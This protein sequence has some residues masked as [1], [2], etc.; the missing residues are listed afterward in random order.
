MKDLSVNNIL[1]SGQSPVVQ[2]DIGGEPNQIPLNKDLGS[3]AY[4][5]AP[6]IEDINVDTLELR[7]MAAEISDTAVDVFVYDTR[8]DSD[9]GAWRSRTQHTSWYNEEL[10]TATRGGR[11]EFPAVAVIVAESDKIIIYDGDDPDLPM[12]MIFEGGNGDTHFLGGATFTAISILNGKLICVSNGGARECD[13]ISEFIFQRRSSLA[14]TKI[15]YNYIS[16]RNGSLNRVEADASSSELIVNDVIH[17]VA[18]TVLPNAP[19]DSDTG[20]PVPTIAVATDGGVS[21]IRDNGSVVDSVVTAAIEAIIFDEQKNLLYYRENTTTM[22]FS[23]NYSSASFSYDFFRTYGTVPANFTDTSTQNK[24]ISFGKDNQII[25]GSD[26]EGISRL[27]SGDGVSQVGD[28]QLAAYTTSTYNTGWMPGDIKLATLSDTKNETVGVDESELVSNGTFD[29]NTNNWS[30]TNSTTLSVDNQRLKLQGGGASYPA[31]YTSVNVVEGVEYEVSAEYISNSNSFSGRIR[32][33]SS[34]PLGAD[35]VNG[36]IKTA[37]TTHI[38]RFTAPSTGSVYIALMLQDVNGNSSGIWDNV[39]VKRVA[40]LVE[41]GTFDSDSD[42]TKE[43]GW[44]INS[45]VASCANGSSSDI[46]QSITTEVGKTYV[47]T[48]DVTSYTSGSMR[49]YT[50]ST[51]YVVPSELQSEGKKSFTFTATTASESIRIGASSGLTASIDNISVRLAEDDRSVNDNGLQVFGEITKSP[52]APGADLVAYSGFS[53]D[54]YL[55]QPYN[56]DLEF[57]TGDFCVMGWARSSGASQAYISVGPESGTGARIISGV[58]SGNRWF[59]TAYDNTDSNT[60]RYL[61]RNLS[62]YSTGYD[63]VHIVAGRKDGVFFF[64]FNNKEMPD[65]NNTATDSK[66]LTNTNSTEVEL[67]IGVNWQKTAGGGELA[68][69]RISKTAPTPE[70]IAKIYRDEKALFTDGAQATL[71]GTSDAVTALAYDDKTELLHVGTSSGRSDFSGLR[72]I[73]NTTTAVTTSISA[74]NNLIAEQ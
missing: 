66:D 53:A 37:G 15:Y 8:K 48:W 73:N 10:N 61:S 55:M 36:D 1:I 33:S 31:A 58:D 44:T 54:D 63:W 57:G 21:V 42:W 28:D 24:A 20:L 32:V 11:R 9:G 30:S 72:R 52:V 17:D 34:S 46:I 41:N 25:V 5:N 14:N 60:T 7:E 71:Y 6:Q 35:I 65:E 56:S 39:S 43:S 67:K 27:T 51:G 69:V 38:N 40:D 49:Y 4:M 18:I 22:Y 50:V 16:D 26:S 45:G 19:I 74:S 47:V 13:F 70:Q 12:W 29:S 3:L 59:F 23:S 2:S 64:Y 62:T 68:L